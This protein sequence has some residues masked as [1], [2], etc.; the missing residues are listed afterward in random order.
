MARNNKKKTSGN[1]AAPAAKAA[2][3]AKG[4]KGKG[5]AAGKAAAPPAAAKG[6]GGKPQAPAVAGGLSKDTLSKLESLLSEVGGMAKRIKKLESKKSEPASLAEDDDASDSTSDSDD[7]STS[8]HDS[9]LSPED[10]EKKRIRNLAKFAARPTRKAVLDME[11]ASLLT[12]SPEDVVQVESRWSDWVNAPADEE[13]RRTRA[14][15]LCSRIQTEFLDPAAGPKKMGSAFFEAPVMAAI[16]SIALR[17]GTDKE[18]LA[19]IMSLVGTRCVFIKVAG[20]E[21]ISRASEWWRSKTEMSLL[22]KSARKALKR[23]K[24]KKGKR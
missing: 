8:S 13:E 14:N 1:A 7:S 22:D 19:K 15:T 5:A 3:G 6:K 21:G 18:K 11:T 4:A 10:K 12:L 9:K 2:G 24:A 16:V 17:A 23:K 20:R